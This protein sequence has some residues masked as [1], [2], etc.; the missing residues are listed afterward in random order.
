MSVETQ[1]QADIE[2]NL[3]G[4]GRSDQVQ[5]IKDVV[6]GD[7]FYNCLQA[8]APGRNAK[9]QGYTYNRFLKVLNASG[10]LPVELSELNYGSMKVAQKNMV[11]AIIKSLK[12]EVQGKK[13]LDELKDTIL[14]SY[15]AV[16]ISVISV[17]NLFYSYA[18]RVINILIVID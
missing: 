10:Y 6:N 17:N 3:A 9:S 4:D 5:A 2:N 12:E 16:P 11:Q 8:I 15:D 18:F 7:G 14:H 13:I 1:H